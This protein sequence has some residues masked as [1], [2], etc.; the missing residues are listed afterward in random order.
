MWGGPF[1][2][3]AGLWPGAPHYAVASLEDSMTTN[4]DS[5]T[6]TAKNSVTV[7]EDTSAPQDRHAPPEELIGTISVVAALGRVHA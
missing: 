4:V 1:W 6:P 3:A 7:L 2:A 5:A